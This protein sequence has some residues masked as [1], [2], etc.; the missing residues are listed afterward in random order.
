M[1]AHL[2]HADQAGENPTAP[3]ILG[4]RV[5][6]PGNKADNRLH[7]GFFMSVHWLSLPM[8]GPVGRCASACRFLVPVCQPRRF[9][10]PSWQ[11][12]AVQ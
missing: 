8:G 3:A 10:P 6:Q 12:G 5:W 9:R 1:L 4:A 11:V 2:D 7:G